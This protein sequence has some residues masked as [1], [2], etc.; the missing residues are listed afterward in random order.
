M[1]LPVPAT[2]LAPS[3]QLVRA[4]FQ[5]RFVAEDTHGDVTGEA[6]VQSERLLPPGQRLVDKGG[7]V[8]ALVEI[9]NLDAFLS[10]RRGGSPS[11]PSL[12]GASGEPTAPAIQ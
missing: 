5:P 9:G 10:Q 11:C 2:C 3:L 4:R 1:G 8:A 6:D 7:P 12:F